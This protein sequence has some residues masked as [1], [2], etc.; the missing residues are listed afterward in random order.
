M[1]PMVPMMASGQ[2]HQ[3]TNVWMTPLLWIQGFILGQRSWRNRREGLKNETMGK[4]Q[5]RRRRGNGDVESR[6][7]GSEQRPW[8]EAASRGQSQERKPGQH[9]RKAAGPLYLHEGSQDFPD[10]LVELLSIPLRVE[11]LQ[12]S[13]QPVVLTEKESVGSGQ[14]DMLR[15][16][17]ISWKP[18]R[19]EGGFPL[20]SPRAQEPAH[21]KINDGAPKGPSP[22]PLLAVNLR[23]VKWREIRV[24][25]HRVDSQLYTHTF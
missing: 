16:S 7:Y 20:S 14:Q 15:G 18:R 25:T 19:Q 17:G 5:Q 21:K 22:K 6:G 8:D 4:K 13:G 9:V 2:A 11:S 3:V 10:F 24:G 12:F 1:E 23:E